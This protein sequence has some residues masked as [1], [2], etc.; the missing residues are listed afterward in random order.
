MIGIRVNPASV[1]E[2]TRIATK[3]DEQT[4]RIIKTREVRRVSFCNT[5]EC[6]HLDHEC[7]DT[8]FSTVVIPDPEQ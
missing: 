2:G 1:V 3:F 4:L 8:R 6:I 5:P 7:Y